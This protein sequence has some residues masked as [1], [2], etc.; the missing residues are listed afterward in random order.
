MNHGWT[1]GQTHGRKTRKHIASA[2]AYRRRRLKNHL[3]W[4][5]WYWWLSH[6]PTTAAVYTIQS[7]VASWIWLILHTNNIIWDTMTTHWDI[8]ASILSFFLSAFCWW[9]SDRYQD[10]YCNSTFLCNAEITLCDKII[11]IAKY[12]ASNRCV[13]GESLYTTM[14]YNNNNSK[15]LVQNSHRPKWPWLNL[16]YQMSKTAISTYKNGHTTTEMI[17]LRKQQGVL[18]HNGLSPNGGSFLK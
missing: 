16:L 6:W 9:Q 4:Q 12:S 15:G 5:W 14:K 10:S 17:E 11:Y 3:P 2:G 7:T 1:H 8:T 13:L 18:V